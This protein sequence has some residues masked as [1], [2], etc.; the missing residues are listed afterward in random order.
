MRKPLRGTLQVVKAG[1]KGSVDFCSVS[2]L[3]DMVP[4]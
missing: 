2:S 3:M 4:F 1:R